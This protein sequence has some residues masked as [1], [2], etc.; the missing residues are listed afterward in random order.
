MGNEV[1]RLEGVFGV[2][3]RVGRMRLGDATTDVR[4]ADAGAAGERVRARRAPFVSHGM[5]TFP[6][7][8]TYRC[9]WVMNRWLSSGSLGLSLKTDGF[10]AMRSVRAQS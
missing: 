3:M 5:V 10:S 4:S 7:A 9:C 1:D 2:R 8:S 6:D